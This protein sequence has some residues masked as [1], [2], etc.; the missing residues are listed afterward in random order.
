MD[1]TL[2]N[3]MTFF[4]KEK[5]NSLTSNLTN[6]ARDKVLKASKDY[7][8]KTA[9]KIR[10][11]AYVVKFQSAIYKQIS[12][13][14]LLPMY[15]NFGI[16]I[17]LQDKNEIKREMQSLRTMALEAKEQITEYIQDYDIFFDKIISERLEDIKSTFDQLKMDDANTQS[18][19]YHEIE[20]IEENSI[21]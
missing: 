12:S 10:T 2:G 13:E 20:R 16:F 19:F 5:N 1:L 17:A 15:A 21:E 3:P 6:T 18:I 14:H 9:Y 7:I 8:F 11:I 4:I